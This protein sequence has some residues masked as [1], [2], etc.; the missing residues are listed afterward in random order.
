MIK[1]V[2]LLLVA[3][4]LATPATAILPNQLPGLI[5]QVL[6]QPQFNHSNWGISIV[7]KLAN[8]TVLPLYELNPSQFFVP[9]S[10]NKIPTTAATFLFLGPKFH[11]STPVY[12][13]FQNNNSTSGVITDMCLVGE[14]DASIFPHRQLNQLAKSL[15]QRF[16]LNT[17]LQLSLDDTAFPA[18]FPASWEWEDVTETDGAQPN[19]L[20][21][22]ENA[23]GLS[24]SPTSNGNPPSISFTYPGDNVCVEIINKAVT[25][26]S[27]E[28]ITQPLSVG[29][30]LGKSGIFVGGQIANNSKAISWNGAALNPAERFK[31]L[32]EWEFNQASISI[33]NSEIKACN[34]CAGK[35]FPCLTTSTLV[36]TIPSPSLEITMNHTLQ[37][38]D[39]LF[40]E[41]F[42]RLLGLQWSMSL[43][44][45]QDAFSA[46]LSAVTAILSA[47][48]VDTTLFKQFD[49]SG[50]SRH[51]LMSPAAM[52]QI[53]LMMYDQPS[54][55]IY[56]SFLPVAGESGTLKSRMAGTSAQ[57]VIHAK[58]GTM[59][60]VNS[61]SGYMI[62][63]SFPTG[64]FSLSSVLFLFP[65][66]FDVGG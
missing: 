51:N 28:T 34:P 64:S 55:D 65:F 43:G 59:T 6:A 60:G 49:G 11:I 9:A 16:K 62:N 40:A 21:A 61:L 48:G 35:P 36:G 42:L 13:N 7:T 24:V 50:L 23:I 25:V 5:E 66:L 19:S 2:A 44:S 45:K 10:N 63:D 3:F 41:T 46:G 17:V 54:G 30:V 15:V 56:R 1:V 4:C 14:G 37:E 52:I 27:G 57:G 12:G 38:S 29:Y 39:N 53:F 58:T 18:S 47:N 31:C 32:L 22:N 26:G 33:N 8:G 20:I